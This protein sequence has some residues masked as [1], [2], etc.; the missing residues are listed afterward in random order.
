MA[1]ILCGAPLGGESERAFFAF[2]TRVSRKRTHDLLMILLM[3]LIIIFWRA[4]V[5]TDRRP[6]R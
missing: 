3:I 2:F 6:Y 4:W 1:A 5:K